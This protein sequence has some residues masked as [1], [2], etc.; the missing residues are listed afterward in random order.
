MS[1]PRYEILDH[2]AD[3]ALRAH[4]ADLAELLR[5]L[6][7]GLIDQIAAADAIERRQERAI[8]LSAADL[9]ELIVSFANEL[10]FH[11][12]SERLL[13]PWVTVRS[14]SDTALTATAQGEIVAERHRFK[15]E[16]K[17]ATYHALAIRRPP[18]STAWSLDLVVDV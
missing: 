16:L 2:T 7:Y 8:S 14:V 6:A 3:L 5:S 12:E 4:G 9:P 18:E 11:F 1:T 15:G 10:L 17:S 13:L